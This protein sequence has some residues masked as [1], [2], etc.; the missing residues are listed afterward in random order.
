MNRNR[1]SYDRDVHDVLSLRNP[2]AQTLKDKWVDKAFWPIGFLDQAVA[3]PVW[4]GAYLK[5][6][7]EGKAEADAVYFADSI[8][9]ITQPTG[10]V[11]DLS[12]AQRGWGYGDAG[13]LLTM[14]STFF[15]GT[16]NLLWEQFHETKGHFK[17][18]EFLKGTY[19]AGRAVWFMA[20]LPALMEALIKE[21]PPEDED[22]LADIA[23]SVVSFTTG[24]MPVVKDAVSYWTGDSFR[25][26]PA[27]VI[28]SMEAILK[29]PGGV[30]EMLG[31]DGDA[32]KGFGQ[33]VRGLGPLTGLPSGQ[34]GATM[35]GAQDWEDNEGFEAFYRLLVRGNPK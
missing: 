13:K 19:R 20:V 6:V 35:K 3:N 23:K 4:L 18:G 10:A 12:R 31:E 22:D 1:T 25:F 11:K 17:D 29:A 30:T 15:S 9:R 5:A 14:F 16:Q 28:D 34:I 27:P 7:K 2:L 33:L 8:V 21:G 24:G 32:A 26:R